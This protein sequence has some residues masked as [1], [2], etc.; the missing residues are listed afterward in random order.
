MAPAAD[1]T[2]S[3]PDVTLVAD[4]KQTVN[5]LHGM[6]EPGGVEERLDPGEA[7]NAEGGAVREYLPF[8]F[9]KTDDVLKGI[10][11][12]EMRGELEVESRCQRG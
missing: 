7:I 2:P 12:D 5:A 6:R 3:E 4:V 8:M 9:D 10:V 11:N 1:A